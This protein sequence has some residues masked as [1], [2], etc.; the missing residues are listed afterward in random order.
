MNANNIK[1]LKQ[2]LE[3]IKKNQEE[4]KQLFQKNVLNTL[5]WNYITLIEN[6]IRIAE[7]T[8]LLNLIKE[9]TINEVK[10]IFNHRFLGWEIGK[11]DIENITQEVRRQIVI[12]LNYFDF[13]GVI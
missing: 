12:Q 8:D 1:S 3:M 13:N 10:E 6:E 9:K 7:Y 4:L 11:G 5:S 2:E